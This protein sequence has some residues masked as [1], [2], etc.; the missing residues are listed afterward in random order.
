MKTIAEHPPDEMYAT[1]LDIDCC[2]ARCGSSIHME[3]CDQCE[4][5]FDGHDCGEDCCCCRYPEENVPCQYCCGRGFFRFCMSSEEYCVNNPLRGRE[6][7]QRG[8][9]EWFTIAEAA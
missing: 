7:V 1:G 3:N 8:T 9:L 2:C 4:D 5:G 6:D